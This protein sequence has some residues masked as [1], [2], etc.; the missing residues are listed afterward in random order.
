MT[1]LLFLLAASLYLAL[2]IGGVD[3]GQMRFGLIEARQEAALL[4]EKQ[5]TVAAADTPVSRA[6]VARAPS[7]E[8]V[9]VA[10]VP[11]QPLVIP[12]A[13]AP[14]TETPTEVQYVTGSSVNV[15]SGPS[16]R[17][18][19]VARLTRGEAVTVV[20]MEDNG[21]ARVRIEGDG[22]DGFMSKDFLTDIAP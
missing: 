12:A 11:P 1:R 15:R 17:D 20:W 3:R 4:A 5:A 6:K 14:I 13:A 7:P 9:G 22:I 21:W 16:T 18:A 8:V 2:L 19:V 10:F